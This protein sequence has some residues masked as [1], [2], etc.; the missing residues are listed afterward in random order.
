VLF[1]SLPLPAAR[2]AALPAPAAA[3]GGDLAA[4]L[5][6]RAHHAGG[7]AHQAAW[8]RVLARPHLP[9]LAL[10]DAAVAEP[11]Q[12]HAALHAALVPSRRRRVQPPGRAGR[13]V[14]APRT[15]R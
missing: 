7:R 14:G 2:S 15:A 13:A 6:D 8:R 11:A 4:A 1:R 3:S 9:L 5:A 12:P 10:R